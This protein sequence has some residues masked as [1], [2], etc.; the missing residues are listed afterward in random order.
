MKKMVFA[1]IVMMSL[2]L[3]SM[4]QD[5]LYFVP[6]KKTEKK[7]TTGTPAKVVVEKEKAPTTV[8][9]A[10]GATVVVKDVQGNVRDVDE[11]N[12]RY[13]SRDNTF[14]YENDTLYIEEKPYSE[15]GE[16]VNGF[17]GSQDDYEYAMRIIRF[18][19]PYFAIPVSSPLY[20]DVVYTL[21]SWEW[22]VFDDGL[23]AYVFPTYSNRLWWDWRWN[24]P[25]GSSWSYSWYSPWWD[26][27]YGPGYWGAG[28]W[29]GYWGHHH[30]HWYPHWHHHHH[31]GPWYA[32]VGG[33]WGGGHGRY[34]S[35][36]VRPGIHAGRYQSSINRNNLASSSSRRQVST[37][38]RSGRDSNTAVR[39]SRRAN[40]TNVSRGDANQQRVRR[41]TTGRVVRSASDNP[42]SVRPRTSAVRNRNGEATSVRD[43]AGVRRSNN[44]TYVRSTESR[45]SSYN[46]PS[47][48]RSSVNNRSESTYQRRSSGNSSGNGSYRSSSSSRSS[49][50]NSSYRSSSSSSRSSGSSF[51][52]GGGSSRSSS[53]G[54]SSRSGGGGGSRSGRR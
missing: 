31:H 12:R 32:G 51:S 11:Y 27:W 4:A 9:A 17:E 14:E 39:Q 38:S 15:R 21:P 19:N 34:G 3:L 40:G 23:Y 30:H 25:W 16:W 8:Y 28:Y 53:G 1:W 54:G 10:P 49:R 50:D 24:Y 44:N 47:S 52:S 48:T 29:G 42:N 6:K 2:P 22:N 5:D 7:V 35:S 36:A 18:R 45:G 41:T 20:W 46:R 37:A 33:Y 26:S 43:A 13:T